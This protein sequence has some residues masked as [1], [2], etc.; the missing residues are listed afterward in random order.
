MKL[1]TIPSFVPN[2]WKHPSAVLY[3]KIYKSGNPIR[4]IVGYTGSIAYQ[5]S[6]ALAEIIAPLVVKSEHHV[7][8]SK[9]LAEEMTSVYIDNGEIFNSHD[10]VCLSANTL[11]EKCLDIIK[12]R[13]NEDTTLKDGTKLNSVDIIELLQFI[14]TITHLVFVVRFIARYLVLPCAQL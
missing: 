10:V 3:Y 12:G 4:S 9:S 13:L 14:L 11:I 1:K 6:E 7:V 5:T 8:N 2:G